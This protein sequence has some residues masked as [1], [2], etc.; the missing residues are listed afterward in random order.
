MDCVV[1]ASIWSKVEG[2]CAG[3]SDRDIICHVCTCVSL[4]YRS[5]S[6]P[7]IRKWRGKREGGEKR[8][9]VSGDTGGD[10]PGKGTWASHVYKLMYA[11]QYC[12]TCLMTLNWLNFQV[13]EVAFYPPFSIHHSP[14]LI[15]LLPR[16]NPSFESQT[17]NYRTLVW[18]SAR[19]PPLWRLFAFEV[20]S[21]IG[22][23]TALPPAKS[24]SSIQIITR[25]RG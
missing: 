2:S 8:E 12:D 17:F 18:I 15:S 7:D 3:N 11:F 5:V 24:V 1:E 13:D 6:I 21:L 22:K 9:E 20:L 4:I 19:V 25:I 14:C 16:D 23:W 10:K